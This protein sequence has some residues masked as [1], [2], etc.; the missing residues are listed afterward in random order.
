MYGHEVD[1]NLFSAIEHGDVERVTQALDHCDNVN[2]KTLYGNS[3]IH[4]ATSYGHLEIVQQLLKKGADLNLQDNDGCSP[5]LLASEKGHTKIVALLLANGAD[6]NKANNEG[7]SPLCW[8]S[9]IGNEEIVTRLLDKG[10]NHQQQ[11]NDG[12]SPLHLASSNGHKE[13]VTLL[14]DKG[15]DPNQKEKDGW[16]PLHLAS[17]YGHTEIVALLLNVGADPDLKKIDGWSPLHLASSNDHKEVVKQLLVRG[18]NPELLTNGG[19]SPLKLAKLWRTEMEKI[20]Q[21]NNDFLQHRKKRNKITSAMENYPNL[22]YVEI[23][24][25]LDR[26]KV[27]ML[28]SS[29]K[30]IFAPKKDKVDE[31]SLWIE[32]PLDIKKAIIG[33]LLDDEQKPKQIDE[34]YEIYKKVTLNWQNAGL[35]ERAFKNLFTGRKEFVV[36]RLEKY[37]ITWNQLH[38]ETAQSFL[39][40]GISPVKTL[41]DLK[42]NTHTFYQT[43][44]RAPHMTGVKKALNFFTNPN[45]T[46]MQGKHNDAKPPE[47][48][49]EKRTGYD[50][51]GDF[52]KMAAAIQYKVNGSE[53]ITL[54]DDKGE[55]FTPSIH[56]ISGPNIN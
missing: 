7:L 27:M 34:H 2:Q 16:S 19:E 5:L 4:W 50:P 17:R 49:K 46:K 44:D 28:L 51:K 25:L 20:L 48:W 38:R 43:F 6:P 45:K 29:C 10:A 36:N 40:H 8:A 14:L 32:L 52:Y 31:P 13:I 35:K 41:E 9:H 56:E 26:S 30:D 47:K 12:W 1:D 21:D 55:D 22:T 18:A 11:D 33:F 53:S 15:A 3:P 23:E 37:L 24:F 39:N 42:E 54:K